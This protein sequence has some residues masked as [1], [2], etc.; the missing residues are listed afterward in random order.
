MTSPVRIF[1]ELPFKAQDDIIEDALRD[2]PSGY[3]YHR[4][5]GI[6]TV[7]YAVRF[8]DGDLVVYDLTDTYLGVTFKTQI[9]DDEA[10]DP[11]SAAR[12]RALFITTH[13]DRAITKINELLV[14][15]YERWLQ[16]CALI[17]SLTP[18][19]VEVARKRCDGKTIREIALEL[20]ISYHTANGYL[21]QIHDKLG[22]HDVRSLCQFWSEMQ[23]SFKP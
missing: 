8:G 21:K 18:R 9:V 2:L 1:H 13:V 22:V 6:D 12:I 23:D 17:K 10:L 16:R 14:L 5:S 7:F 19:E 20:H 11:H 15:E 4:I 3:S